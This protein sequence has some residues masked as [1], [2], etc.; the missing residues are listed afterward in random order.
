MTLV[1]AVNTQFN[2]DR[3][4]DS[5][6]SGFRVPTAQLAG[7]SILDRIQ[8][9]ATVGSNQA[10]GR[11]AKLGHGR[12]G[13][14]WQQLATEAQSYGVLNFTANVTGR[15][16]HADGQETCNGSTQVMAEPHCQ[17]SDIWL[18]TPDNVILYQYGDSF[19]ELFTYDGK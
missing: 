16:R 19:P 7:F 10:A 3:S 1:A 14:T 4:Q 15:H 9:L 17:E 12:A 6:L 2:V 8:L 18:L 5:R 11:G 13:K